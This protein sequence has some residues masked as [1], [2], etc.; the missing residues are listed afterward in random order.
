MSE[1]L[2]VFGMLLTIVAFLWSN[3]RESRYIR[4][5]SRRNERKK[6]L[7]LIKGYK[8]I[9]A[10]PD[11]MDFRRYLINAIDDRDRSDDI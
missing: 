1:I 8:P 10:N 5:Q 9:S 2:V 7:E 11:V 6:I 3:T 4:A